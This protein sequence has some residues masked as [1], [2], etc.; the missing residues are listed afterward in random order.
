[1]GRRRL[2]CATV[3][4][5]RTKRLDQRHEIARD[6]DETLLVLE[7]VREVQTRSLCLTVL[8][9]FVALKHTDIRLTNGRTDIG[10]KNVPRWL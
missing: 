8:L 3:R 5:R 10:Q 7:T 6:R 1:M 2:Y 4:A 9:G